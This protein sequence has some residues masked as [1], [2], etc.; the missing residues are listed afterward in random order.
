MSEE[1]IVWF[2]S[3]APFENP[4]YAVVVVVEGGNS[5]GGT[6]GPVARRIY[7]AI[8]KRPPELTRSEAALVRTG[9]DTSEHVASGL[10]AVW[11]GQIGPA[12]AA[13]PAPSRQGRLSPAAVALGFD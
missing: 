8:I 1:K 11:G 6:C 13:T 9:S 4:R 10:T 3:Y 2:V 12:Q 7:E 5:G